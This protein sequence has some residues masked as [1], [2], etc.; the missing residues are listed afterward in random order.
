NAQSRHNY[1][2]SYF[3]AH[4]L[5]SFDPLMGNVLT[6]SLQLMSS[7]TSGG[8]NA[9]NL[10]YSV[11]SLNKERQLATESDKN[12]SDPL[13]QL[14]YGMS[15]SVELM[16]NSLVERKEE[17]SYEPH[18][19]ANTTKMSDRT[20]SETSSIVFSLP[21]P[22]TMPVFA[23]A[24]PL[25][26]EVKEESSSSEPPIINWLI[27]NASGEL[28]ED[29]A[30]IDQESNDASE[31]AGQSAQGDLVCS[32]CGKRTRYKSKM[33]IHERTHTGEKPFPC[34][35]PSCRR[36]FAQITLL[37]THMQ[38]MHGILAHQC[39]T[40]HAR[41]RKFSELREHRLREKHSF[42]KSLVE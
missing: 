28:D 32:Y 33:E 20:A 34:T 17:E 5:A 19:S 30:S 38:Q 18:F 22:S 21:T 1:N 3:Q 15:Q 26:E 23:I 41:F 12:S 6:K 25:Y 10:A 31:T 42:R 35:I 4:A 37:R 13:R 16:I 39:T 7:I 40:C 8:L 24:A 2:A 9:S 14:M 11:Q 27:D 36:A 29:D